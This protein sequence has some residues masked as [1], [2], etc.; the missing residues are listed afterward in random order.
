MT[1]PEDLSLVAALGAALGAG[2]LSFLSPCVLPLVPAWLSY[3]SGYGLGEIA[4]GRGR[5]RI[6]AR[7]LAFALGFT[8]VFVAL[9]LVFS[10]GALIAGG[11]GLALRLASGIAVLVLGLNLIFD[12]LK[13]LNLERRV[14]AARPKEGKLKGLLGALVL[15]IAFAAGWSPCIGP[16]L[17]S[18]LLLAAREGSLVRASGLLFAYSLGLAIPFIAAGAAFDRMKPVLDWA[19]R[20]GRGIR[21]GAG[22]FLSLL[23]ILMATGRLGLISSWATRL[24]FSIKEALIANGSLLKAIDLSALALLALATILVPILRQKKP[25]TLPRLIFLALLLA[26]ALGEA[27]G[28]WSLAGILS[29]WLTFQGA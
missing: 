6:I 1:G 8:L 13:F 7:S 21:I 10:G 18:I 9:G 2:L 27:L 12:F 23:G 20:R 28:A 15:G 26:A 29:G 11:G 16:I 3:L 5:G 14:Q 19:K 17:A 25:T 22:I 4:S 24:G